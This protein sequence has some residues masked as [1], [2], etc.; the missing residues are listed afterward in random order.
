MTSE[1]RKKLAINPSLL[2]FRW[3][4]RTIISSTM[5]ETWR[6]GI[7]SLPG[8]FFHIPKWCVAG[9]I[10]TKR[11]ELFE[12]S[13]KHVCEPY[14][15]F[16]MVSRPNWPSPR[17]NMMW[18]TDLSSS[19]IPMPKCDV[20]VLVNPLHAASTPVLRQYLVHRNL[21]KNMTIFEEQLQIVR[22]CS[23][24][25]HKIN[26]CCWARWLVN[27]SKGTVQE[28]AGSV[29]CLS[30]LWTCWPSQDVGDTG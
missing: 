20:C 6:I 19:A 3:F 11:Q 30:F 4:L 14:C 13:V 2:C 26:R 15:I 24:S 22:S 18:V 8:S 12:V 25:L 27:I 29:Y 28:V 7:Q 5:V 23:V 9:S 17:L 21:P 16:G 1:K 10:V